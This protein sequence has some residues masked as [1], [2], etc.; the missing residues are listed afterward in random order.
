M[1]VRA[2]LALV[3]AFGVMAQRA[4]A[5]QA[6][7]TTTSDRTKPVVVTGTVYDS[8]AHAPLAGAHV[9][10]VDPQR[11]SR[12]Y[13]ATTNS[14]GNFTM[15]A[16]IP[17]RYA[18]GFF[19]PTLD[20][21]GV[22]PPLTAVEIAPGRSASIALAVPGEGVVS[23]ALCGE[24][25]PTD[26]SGALVGIVRD[27]DSGAP[28]SDAD[29]VVTWPELTISAAGIQQVQRRVPTRTREDGGYVLCGIPNGRVLA[30]ADSGAHRSGLLEIDVPM[31]GLV[32]RDFAVAGPDAAVATLADST[33]GAPKTIVLRGTARLA[34]VVRGPDGH[35]VSGAR[36]TVH[37]SGLSATTDA[38]GA[39]SIAGL[40]AGTF[41]AQA[42]AIGLSPVT[43][44]VDLASARTDSVTIAL[45]DRA[46]TR[47]AAVTVY[48]RRPNTLQNMED[49]AARR[50]QGFGHYLTVD[51]LRNRITVTDALK[52]V[53]GL[54]VVP[55]ATG[56]A[57]YG[58]GG[59]DRFGDTGCSAPGCRPAVYLDG[60]RLPDQPMVLSEGGGVAEGDPP[61]ID[62]Y[63]D[64]QRVMGIEVYNGVGGVPGQFQTFDQ[65][66]GCG[67]ILIWSKR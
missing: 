29:V 33:R 54:H 8:V 22:Q 39:F 42:R 13:E 41:A 15:A 24:R 3:A 67:V 48:G 4:A 11:A 38:S 20:A 30:S 31:H 63:I 57:V 65:T 7:S 18:A 64:P 45:A 10:L 14:A 1:R 50:R 66:A 28:L 23:A 17:G 21:L 35:P 6:D 44:P 47:L 53:A 51:D 2:A 36:V 59:C 56:V 12:A 61:D 62:Q 58:R 9:Q 40:P 52:S 26:S 46:T 49:F 37:G 34:G 43:V 55:T 25:A 19:H 5:M 16:V 60:N 27:A 32:R